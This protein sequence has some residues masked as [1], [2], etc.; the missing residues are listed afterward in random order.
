[1]DVQSP[2]L[3]SITSMQG[4][5]QLFTEQKKFQ[6]IVVIPMILMA[7]YIVAIVFAYLPVDFQFCDN[8][9]CYSCLD[10]ASPFYDMN[11]CTKARQ[12]LFN[13]NKNYQITAG[14]IAV[15]LLMTTI[16]VKLFQHLIYRVSKCGYLKTG[17]RLDSLAQII[18]YFNFLM[19]CATAI[20]LGIRSV[21][22]HNTNSLF[23]EVLD[24]NRHHQTTLQVLITI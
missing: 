13:M 24:Q 16:M 15:S 7:S 6:W 3:N 5:T 22:Q 23:Y 21:S 11:Y 4:E 9:I 14:V 19:M 20:A 8:D 12:Y 10:T 2:L 18:Y 1:M 17:Q